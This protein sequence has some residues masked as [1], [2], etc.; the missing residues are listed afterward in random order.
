MPTLTHKK[1]QKHK[2]NTQQVCTRMAIIHR[3]IRS[4]IWESNPEPCSAAYVT[5]GTKGL[6][7]K[8]KPTMYMAVGTT[9][10]LIVYLKDVSA[11]LDLCQEVHIV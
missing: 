1:R 10:L 9:Q 8:L 7:T 3:Y 5:F 2:E 11:N 6:I 4:V